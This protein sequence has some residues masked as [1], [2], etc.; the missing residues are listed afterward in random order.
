[1]KI[2]RLAGHALLTSLLGLAVVGVAPS[3]H[4]TDARVG[5]IDSARIFREYPTAQ[6]AQKR[7]D[8]QVQGW[9]DEAAE[10]E[11]AV[12]QLRDEVRDQGPIL[13]ALKRQEKEETL[14]R[15]ISEYEQFIQETWGPQG[16]AT[17]ENEQAT[18][19]VITQIRAVV[20]KVAANKGLQLVLDASSGF[21]IYADR[22]L[23]LTGDVLTELNT[24]LKPGGT[25]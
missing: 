6:E 10:K 9:R 1:M 15:A 11:K 2:T 8:R 19:V 18:N 17:R 5:Y 12:K 13:S 23:D 24:G 3:A 7:F 25:H 21:I 22:S 4:A 20:E 14:Q 16:R